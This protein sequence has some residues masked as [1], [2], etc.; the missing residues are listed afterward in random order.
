MSFLWGKMRDKDEQSCSSSSDEERINDDT[1]TQDDDALRSPSSSLAHRPAVAV[2]LSNNPPPTGMILS[3]Q[4]SRNTMT[5]E[6]AHRLACL[7]N[8]SLKATRSHIESQFPVGEEIPEE[9]SLLVWNEASIVDQLVTL[10][11][12][13]LAQQ[14]QSVESSLSF[15]WNALLGIWAFART[16]RNDDDED[17]DNEEEQE[18]VMNGDL[19]LALVHPTMARSV[20]DYLTSILKAHPDEII[21]LSPPAPF[22]KWI[23]QQEK[24]AD[25]QLW[26]SSL[27]LDELKVLLQV[28]Q[29]T[30]AP[31]SVH[32]TPSSNELVLVTGTSSEAMS[33]RLVEYDLQQTAVRL[34]REHSALEEQ[35]KRYRTAALAAKQRKGNPIPSMKLYK[36]CEAQMAHKQNHLL[37][38]ETVRMA[39]RQAVNNRS[40]V[41][42]M[43]SARTMLHDIH[44]ELENVHDVM[45]DLKEAMQDHEEVS[46]ALQSA[47]VVGMEDED[48]LLQELQ[49]LCLDDENGDGSNSKES[50]EIP[51]RSDTKIESTNA[52][53][54]DIENMDEGDVLTSSPVAVKDDIESM[55]EGVLLSA[56]PVPAS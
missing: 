40:V 51:S 29:R 10:L 15:L 30:G 23:M 46:A 12:P 39:L 11:K 34:E 20:L 17:S 45:D 19:Q 1:N 22:K 16:N 5:W 35:S 14:G 41:Q 9:D 50:T 3:S 13:N 27:S 49:N 26:L 4:P 24:S 53:Q 31:L 43:G 28:L 52:V 18:E 6:H 55:N 37:Q 8:G 44:K 47:S 21:P 7:Q 25:H 48:E 38:I 32:T 36:L 33:T 56:S 42:A 2:V 54:D